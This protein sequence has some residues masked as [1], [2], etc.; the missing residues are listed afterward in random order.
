MGS[1]LAFCIA[2]QEIQV[3]FILLVSEFKQRMHILMHRDHLIPSL[4]RSPNTAVFHG[5]TQR[6]CPH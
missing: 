4:S 3:R 5:I 1:G 6:R 2:F